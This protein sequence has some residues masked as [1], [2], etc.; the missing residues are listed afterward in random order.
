MNRRNLR[1]TTRTSRRNTVDKG[2][3]SYQSKGDRAYFFIIIGLIIFGTI[4]IFSGSVPVATEHNLPPYHY[5]LKQLQFVVLGLIGFAVVY[6]IDYHFYPKVVLPG[7]AATFIL[8]V[9]VLF[10]E[11]ING[12]NRWLDIKIITFQ[13]A[14]LA[15]ITIILYLASWLSKPQ[16]AEFSRE[17]MESYLK[18]NLAPFLA[19]L[20]VFCFLILLQPDLSV[21]ILVGIIAFSIYFFSGNSVY[22]TIGTL[23]IFATMVVAGVFAAILSPYRL[24]RVRTFLDFLINGQLAEPFGRDYQIRQ[25]L[26]AV[27]T[28]NLLGQGFAQSKQKFSYLTETAFSDTIFAVFA[29][30]FGFLGSIVLVG[31]FAWIMIRGFQIAM[32]APDKLGSLIA[33]GITV[34]L[35]TQSLIHLAVNV[36][37]IPLTGMPLPFL[38]YGG[39]SLIASMVALGI[40]MNISRFSDKY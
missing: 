1:T 18:Y 20:G 33:C 25:I 29:E 9:V 31:M 5:F 37:L 32:N 36:G 34:W 26:I 27:G 17:S 12:V 40:M 2:K 21:T 7:L 24:A 15:K 6:N 28:G 39:S 10:T 8:L 19:I 30:E 22:Q 23:G 35:T 3:A 14:D 4:M 16:Q 11:P 38:S 13:V